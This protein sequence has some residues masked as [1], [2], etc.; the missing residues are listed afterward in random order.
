MTTG[1]IFRHRKTRERMA[2]RRAADVAYSNSFTENERVEQPAAAVA[3]A[4]VKPPD[5]SR[6]RGAQR[7]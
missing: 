1:T 6:D 5:A 2:Q 7:R 3:S 4:S